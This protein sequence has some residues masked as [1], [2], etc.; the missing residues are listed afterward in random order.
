MRKRVV[1]IMLAAAVAAGASL[2]VVV[3]GQAGGSPR[4]PSIDWSPSTSG[5]FDFGLVAGGKTAS[6]TFTLTNSGGSPS[7]ALSVTLSGPPTGTITDDTCTATSP[8][9]GKMGT[10][11][12]QD[13]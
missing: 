11:M 2:V 8:G 7:A 6:Q 4:T 9:T 5:G 3:G 13:T 12:V 10:G 1:R